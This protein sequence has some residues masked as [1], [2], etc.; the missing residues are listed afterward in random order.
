MERAS[1]GFAA[2]QRRDMRQNVV[3]IDEL[4]VAAI[5][6]YQALASGEE[7]PAWST[8]IPGIDK[9]LAGGLRPGKV[10]GIGARPSVGKS[11]LGRFIALHCAQQGHPAMLL[12][13][14]MPRA[15]QADCIISQ[16][17]GV[18]SDRLQTGQFDDEDWN[19]V[20]EAV[21]T[22]R[23]LPFHVDDEGALTLGAIRAKARQV[24]GLQ[25]LVLD[26]LQLT[27]STLK[28]ATRNSQIEEVSRGLKAL[29]MTGLAVIVLLQLNRESEKR[30][31]KKPLLAELRDSGSIE[32]DLD[33]ALLLWT[34]RSYHGGA[35]RTVGCD[36]AKNRG[37]PTGE[38]AL[39]FEASKYRWYDSDEP[40]HDT[41][42]ETMGRKKGGFDG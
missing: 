22:A 10:Y 12:S 34:H 37:G 27:A 7:D 23:N 6:R 20:C 19:R 38:L 33:V 40:L 35:K 36:V 28:D 14:E 15:E 25:V 5:D 3:P 41:R 9:K 8:G 24:K 11:S 31:I 4:M 18:E 39:H 13:Q 1:E 29:A 16:L 30:A 17:G 42:T 32:Q 2:L 21:E 26:Y